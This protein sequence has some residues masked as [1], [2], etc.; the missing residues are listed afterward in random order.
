MI[1]FILIHIAS[2]YYNYY[3]ILG[4]GTQKYD[5]AWHIWQA[6]SMGMIAFYMGLFV[7][8]YSA[9][10]FLLT[11]M[12]FFQNTLN[13]LRG[14]GFFYIGTKG[15]DGFFNNLFGKIAGQ[16]YFT[17]ALL[18]IVALYLLSTRFDILNTEG[19]EIIEKLCR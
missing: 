17:L 14:K 7:N 15:I 1:I 4:Q 11:R 6:I 19:I 9:I 10:L 2:A 13:L 18:S 12:V 5:R 16:V 3:C 8:P